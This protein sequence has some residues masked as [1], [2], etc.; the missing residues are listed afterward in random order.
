MQ[1]K[2][3]ME[4]R[5]RLAAKLIF[6]VGI[7]LLVAISMWSYFSM[8]YQKKKLME[9]VVAATDR[10]STTIR[11][12]THYAMMLNSRDDINQIINNIARVKEIKNI[13]IY[14]KEGQIKYSNQ[15]SEVDSRTN[16]KAEA[17]YICHRTEPPLVDIELDQRTRLSMGQEGYRLLGVISPIGNE[18]GCSSDACH[19]HPHDKK[20]LG[21]LDVVVSLEN[22][23][24]EIGLAETA[25]VGLAGVVFLIP[26]A[27][28]FFF[29]LRFVNRPVRKLIEETRLIGQGLLPSHLDLGQDDEMGQLAVAINQMSAEIALKQTELNKQRDEYQTLVERVPCLITVQDRNLRLLS[30]NGEFR[31]RFGP[32]IGEYCYHAYKG[33]DEKCSQCPVE[34]TFED[35]Q[36]HQGEETG[37]NRDGSK[38]HWIFRTSPIKNTAGQIVA[39]LEMSLDI[40]ERKELE[41]KLEKSERKYHD[42]FNHIP[43]PVFVLDYDSLEVLDCNKSVAAV[44]DLTRTDILGRP[45][46]DLFLPEERSQYAACIRT[47]SEL[48]QIRHVHKNLG[49][50]VVNI[51][52]SP[53]EYPGRKVLLVTTSD[54]TKRLETEQ[55]LIQASKMA[56]LGEMATGI[57]HELNQ[58]LSVIKT[59]SS[60][61]VKKL[62]RQ[63]AID[64]ATLGSMLRKVDGNVDRA[65]RIIDHMRQ[66]ARKSDLKLERVQLNDVIRRAFEIFSQQLKLRSIEVVWEIDPDLPKID[67][68]PG[69]LEQVFINLLLN[70][71]DAI[72]ERWGPTESD[73]EHKRIII[74]THAS[75][76]AVVCEICDTGMGIPANMSEKIFEPFFTTKQA[77]KGTGLGLSISYGIVKDC[78]G[79]IRV[80]PHASG[81]ASFILEFPAPEKAHGKNDPLGR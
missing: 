25:A 27:I 63:Q 15:I 34:R 60:F 81:G 6:T 64:P 57:A 70:A 75:G 71:R 68:D 39:V 5:H 52:I 42:I 18:P 36:P 12:G 78:R 30:F 77:G 10:L 14:N 31:R 50:I 74:R 66:F 32:N 8:N 47:A 53:G 76:P 4:L 43:N 61:F 21:A 1:I 56:T 48:N 24:Q 2:S 11:L 3:F 45:F 20:I 26:S 41:E 67:A 79:S 59:A 7:T 62:D 46:L 9:N 17:C 22:V 40:T 49:R 58:P 38:V 35:G 65:T 23:D 29:V 37:F 28:I 19:V 55:N 73:P 16:I 13:R 80:K 33:R 69:R 44:Y 54:I 72:E 51:R